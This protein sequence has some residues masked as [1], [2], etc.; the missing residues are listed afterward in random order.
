MYTILWS[1]TYIPTYCGFSFLRVLLWG[2]L[3]QLTNIMQISVILLFWHVLLL[4]S[5]CLL[6]QY[7]WIGLN[8]LDWFYWCIL[9]EVCVQYYNKLIF[10]VLLLKFVMMIILCMNFIFF[11]ILIKSLVNNFH[12]DVSIYTSLS[13]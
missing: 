11:N 9:F 7:G 4:R 6:I 8:R 2:R 13:Y 1:T 12:I 5:I 10:V 3:L